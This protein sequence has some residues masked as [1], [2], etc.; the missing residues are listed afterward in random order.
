LSL[1]SMISSPS[2][3]CTA[4]TIEVELGQ[5]RVRIPGSVPAELAAAVLKAL[6]RR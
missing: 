3:T 6:S 1:M 2:K 5:V 4:P